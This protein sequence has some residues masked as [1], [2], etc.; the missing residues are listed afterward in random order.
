[1]RA[2]VV[3]AIAVGAVVLCAGSVEA[4][5]NPELIEK[6]AREAAR[7]ELG[8][9]LFMDPAASRG[10]RFSCKSCHEPEHGFSDPR[11][12]SI[13]ENGSTSRHSQPITD[14]GGTGF[15]WDG[16]FPHV[17]DLL[18]ARLASGEEVGKRTLQ[19][20]EQR[21]KQAERDRRTTDVKTYQRRK[22]QIRRT[23]TPPY[24]GTTP[25]QRR[26]SPQ[27]VAVRIAES[28]LYDAGV[29]AAFGT[30][31]VSASRLVD[32]MEAYLDTVKTSQNSYD[33][34]ISGDTEALSESAHRGLQLFTGEAGCA[35]CH[36]LSARNGRV[37]LTNGGFAN[38]G[39][40]FKG[41]LAEDAVPDVGLASQTFAVDDASRFKVPSLRD[42]ARRPPY[43]HNGSLATLAEV[44]DYYAQ[45]GTKNAHLD[46]RIKPL[47]LDEQERGD[48]VAFLESLSGDE[49]PGLGRLHRDRADV[50]RVR[51]VNLLGQ[52]VKGFTFRGLPAGDRLL[53]SDDGGE[54][55]SVKTD[56]R[57]E[58]SIFMPPSTHL[59]L[60]AN[61]HELGFSRL[62]P[63]YTREI[64]VMAT[65][66]DT[67]AVPV[68]VDDATKFIPQEVKLFEITPGKEGFGRLLEMRRLRMLDEKTAL[69]VA[70]R[71]ELKGIQGVG[72]KIAV[73]RVGHPGELIGAAV[74]F[75][76]GLSELVDLRFAKPFSVRRPFL[77][78]R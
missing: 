76:G 59:R 53:G 50:L 47:D 10:A 23:F 52:P 3:G 64:E 4:G 28:G 11:Q 55:Q 45:G 49:R 56:L 26:P 1:M 2:G 32:A 44:V 33:R 14:L 40:A 62:I 27:P 58:A 18:F 30:P 42:V 69:Y 34:Y 9:R 78:R 73:R 36:Q 20:M 19:I 7:I 43:M 48:L 17:R 25:G 75:D 71:T 29:A 16:E 67:I 5:R 68:R 77:N 13:D 31:T 46:E 51:V 61:G 63:D 66:H 60:E 8:R 38:T 15:H 24:Y 57:G 22:Q 6:D 65:P 21:I 39:V 70:D 74:D 37:A 12:F 41:P 35:S 72:L 54:P